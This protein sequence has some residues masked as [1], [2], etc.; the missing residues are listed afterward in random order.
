MQSVR[1][2]VIQ[3]K[4]NSGCKDCVYFR[5]KT[6]YQS[7]FPGFL[8]PSGDLSRAQEDNWRLAISEYGN[9][10]LRL[11]CSPLRIYINFGVACNLKC[12]MCMQTSERRRNTGQIKAQSILRWKQELLKARDISVIGGEPFLVPEARTFIR[13]IVQ[14]QDFS[15]V[16]LNIFTNG[17][18]LLDNIQDLV[19]KN[20]IN[21]CVSLDSIADA[22]EK[23]R[24]GSSWSLV[25]KNILAFKEAGRQNKLD[26]RVFSANIIMTSSIPKLVNLVEWNIAND[27]PPNFVDFIS[28][29]GLEETFK[30]E[31]V[32]QNPKMLETIEGWEKLF[33]TAAERLMK[34]GWDGSA[35]TL[36]TMKEDLQCRLAKIY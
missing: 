26:W 4:K 18:L 22:Y 30:A 3:K 17:T 1:K 36:R 23:I 21:I 7:Y 12:I 8:S 24:R 15:N 6:G 5:F 32:F 31:N 33:D 2:A 34:K 35:H 9:N 19:R 11:R 10:A 13:S 28:S 27:I 16:E 29:P 25:E 20:K 14:D